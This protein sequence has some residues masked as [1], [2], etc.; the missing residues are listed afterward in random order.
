MPASSAPGERPVVFILD[1]DNTLLDN[2]ALKAD[3]ADRLRALLGPQRDS[4]FWRAYE[5][6]RD[7]AGTVDFPLTIERFRPILH[8]DTLLEGVRA[9]VMDYPYDQ[10]VYPETLA[11]VAHLHAIGLPTIVSDGDQVYQPLKIERSGLAAAVEQRV[12]VYVHKEEHLDEIMALWPAD[13]YVMVD[14]KTRILSATKA[15][16]PDRFVT[17]HVRQ[18]HY[19]LAPVTTTPP[20]DLTLDHIGDLRGLTP[21]ILRPHLITP[22]TN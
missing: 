17:V 12:L 15:R 9:V 11:A 10:R 18:G 1:C 4:A 16:L 20:P 22:R 2:D 3:L 6:V 19:G 14:D 21:D 13:F 7:E 8:D 5:A